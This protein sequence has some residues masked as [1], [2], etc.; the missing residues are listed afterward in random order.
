MNR[1]AFVVAGIF[2]A[3]VLIVPPILIHVHSDAD[4]INILGQSGEDATQVQAAIQAINQANLVLFVIVG[5]V[6]VI[7]IILFAVFLWIAL[8]P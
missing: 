5:V 6:D 1:K 4:L 2:L 3:V 8:K 7:S